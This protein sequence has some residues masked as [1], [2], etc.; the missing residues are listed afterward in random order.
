M[1]FFH[2]INN[3]MLMFQTQ[4]ICVVLLYF[5][6]YDYFSTVAGQNRSEKK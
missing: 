4:V 3:I 6:Q 1:P 2:N 5:T